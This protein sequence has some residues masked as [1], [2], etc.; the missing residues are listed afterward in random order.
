M[1]ELEALLDELAGVV[2]DRRLLE[3]KEYE[4][5][6]RLRNLMLTFGVPSV[7]TLM[8]KAYLRQVSDPPVLCRD[9]ESLYRELGP[10]FVTP[11]IPAL[12]ELLR[13]NPGKVLELVEKGVV[14]LT[15]SPTR[16]TLQV[17]LK[18]AGEVQTNAE[19]RTETQMP[20]S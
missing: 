4:L 3:A 20:V 16:W 2:A 19:D 11:N 1:K 15:D 17:K 13:K 7:E 8:G 6:E 14:E 18:L 9:V 5:R 12:R 10:S